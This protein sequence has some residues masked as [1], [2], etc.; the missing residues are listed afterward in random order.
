MAHSLISAFPD[1]ADAFRAYARAFPDSSTFLVD[2]Y[3]TLAGVRNAITIGLEMKQQGHALRAVRLDSGDLL[4]L[5]RASRRLLDEAGLDAVEVF[6][7][8][9]LDE[10]S[11]DAL[12]KAGAPIAGFG[13]G[14]R[15]GT[16][17]DAPHADFVYK[18]VAFQGQPVMKLSADKVNLPGSK[19]VHR[20]ADRDGSFSGDVIGR[21][22][23]PLPAAE[24]TE[25][26]IEPLLGPVMRG[27]RKLRPDPEIGQVRTAFAEQFARLPSTLKELGT[28]H[29]YDV[30][31]SDELRL[32]TEVTG[33]EL[34]DRL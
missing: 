9:G 24:P 6:A 4:E 22:T 23:E 26:Q 16:S 17:A 12:V 3:D 32:L 25:P 27:G 10:Y 15:L 19:Q 14:T 11:V 5:S 29:S 18:L 13:V 33:Q 8:G 28:T 1:E 30:R 2:T 20:H 21:E 31:V 34:R 7:S